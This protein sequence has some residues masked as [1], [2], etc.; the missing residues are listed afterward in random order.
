MANDAISTCIAA[1]RDVSNAPPGPFQDCSDVLHISVFFDGTGNNKDID[2]DAKKWSNVARMFFASEAYSKQTSNDYPIY[3]SGVGTPYNGKP[4][5][6]LSSAGIWIQDGFPGGGA[7]AGGDRRLDQGDDAVNDRLRDVLILNAKKLGGEVGQYA[8]NSS[9]KT[10]KEVS[11]ALDKHRLIKQINLSIFGFSRGAALARAFSNRVIENCTPKEDKLLYDGRYPIRVNFMGIFDTVASFGVPAANVQL[12]FAER[13]LIV[14]PKVEQC[15]HY[16][17]AHEVRFSFPVDLIRKKGMLANS[18]WIEQTYPGVHSDVGGG[19]KP[20]EQGIK[21]NYARIPMRDMMREAVICGVRMWN[22]DEIKKVRF[23]TFQDR[24]ECNPETETAYQAYRAA[25]GSLS[26][27]VE[28][29]MTQ[30]MKLLYSACGTMHRTGLQSPAERSV[31][32]GK[33]SPIGYSSMAEEIKI[34]RDPAKA[35]RWVRIWDTARGYAQFV[36]PQDW[37]IAA[38]DTNAPKG[39]VDFVSQFVHDSKL[40]IPEPFSYFKPRSV[41]ESTVNIW[42]EGGRWLGGKAKAVGDAVEVGADAAGKTVTE[43]YNATA[44]ATNKAY[45]ASAKAANDAAQ[46]A[47]QKAQQAADYASEKSRQA[48]DATSKAASDAAQAAQRKA[49]EAADHAK[50]MAQKAADAAANTYD[51]VEDGAQRIYEKGTHWI[52]QLTKDATTK[53]NEAGQW[54]NR[55]FR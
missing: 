26:G 54:A 40:D 12:P 45:D 5:R 31:A 51:D 32:E 28:K 53:A 55:L 42:Q 34:Y 39:A 20:V 50:K 29:Q 49:N 19:Y 27:P 6:R 24:F 25:C 30:H 47:K 7:G 15:V 48:Y 9:K 8:T 52:E 23:Q 36:K 2:N 22:Y 33:R 46:A 18:N 43:A 1:N 35:G 17:A 38:W 41:D 21:N 14:S 11:T 37:H 3:I 44:N 16:V 10:F 4:A 13:D